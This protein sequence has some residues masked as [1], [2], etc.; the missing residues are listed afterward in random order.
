VSYGLFLWD[1]NGGVTLDESST[2]MKTFGSFT[3]FFNPA[4]APGYDYG[5]GPWSHTYSYPGIVN[6]GTLFM[7]ANNYNANSSGTIIRTTEYSEG[8]V[9]YV[10]GT[11]TITVVI[12][13]F[14]GITSGLYWN[15]VI[16]RIN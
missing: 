9:S 16:Y 15:N 13:N 7:L 4:T 14:S 6:D 3:G 2:I 10:F 5:V 1:A 12:S 8:T 11:D